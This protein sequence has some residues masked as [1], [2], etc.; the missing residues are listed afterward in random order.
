LQNIKPEVGTIN[1]IENHPLSPTEGGNARRAL[2]GSNKIGNM[3]FDDA[4][5]LNTPH[6]LNQENNSI[7]KRNSD[8]NLGS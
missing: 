8:A 5:N 1:S 7:P 2:Y 6:K 4:G 3:S